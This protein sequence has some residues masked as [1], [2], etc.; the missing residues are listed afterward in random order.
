[1]STGTH[2]ITAIDAD[3][4]TI[5]WEC[6]CGWL[7]IET[8]DAPDYHTPIEQRKDD[9]LREAAAMED[10]SVWNEIPPHHEYRLHLR[11][12]LSDGTPNHVVLTAVWGGG[13]REVMNWSWTAGGL[14]A[15]QAWC[16]THPTTWLRTGF[17][18]TRD[19]LAVHAL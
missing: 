2:A 19:S 18:V 1:M 10:G 6:S 16:D 17:P 7:T 3:E 12:R 15:A 4:T 11:R 14:A 8:I 13:F 9:H 5:T